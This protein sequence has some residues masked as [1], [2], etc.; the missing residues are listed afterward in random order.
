MPEP[1]MHLVTTSNE[2]FRALMSTRARLLLDAAGYLRA[3]P[4]VR[5]ALTRPLVGRLLSQSTQL[6]ELLDA[7]GA[8]RNGTWCRLRAQM[9]ALKRFAG[10]SYVLLHIRHVLPSY[11]LFEIEHDF[12]QATDDALAFSGSV[13][14]ETSNRLWAHA[15]ELGLELPGQTQD[16]SLYA[17][18]LPAGRLL[19]DREDSL[20]IAQRRSVGEIVTHLATAFLNL[21]VKGEVIHAAA[22]TRPE[23]YRDH[24]P[25]S[26]TETH[27]RHLEISFH[28]LQALYDTYVT[29]TRTERLDT[30][31]PVLRGHI[32]VVYHLL[33]IATQLVHYEERHVSCHG[34]SR[35]PALVDRD[36]LIRV[37]MEYALAFA[38]YYLASAENLCRTMLKRYAEVAEVLVSA[39]RY[40]GFHVRPSTLVAK[41]V[42]HYG[43]EVIMSLDGERYDASTPL[44]I[45]RA[46]EKIN[47]AKRRWLAA[48][49]LRCDCLSG[50]I[51]GNGVNAKEL[52]RRLV[53]ELAEQGKV[54]I[55]EKPLKMP[56][57]QAPTEGVLTDWVI[58]ELARLQ[59]L[60]KID[61][62][63]ELPVTFIGDRRV[64]SDIEILARCGY[65][66]DL[67]GN[68]IP[69]PPEIGYLRR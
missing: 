17:E 47:A 20:A 29:D 66:E 4:A 65:G 61:I 54:V 27:L 48:E 14:Y 50:R 44:E 33:E 12:R 69:L 41:I 3:H 26:I 64:L 34:A 67:M 15:A 59:A 7:Y 10:V 63:T 31:L 43:S 23:D 1:A 25:E 53:S 39:P 68:N 6:E 5:T 60:G 55:Y 57:S 38:S 46:N 42:N 21:A 40:R 56:D 13:L 22:R 62:Q 32:S 18:P 16:E 36:G 37:L 30:D 45:F 28:N 51:N 24:L 35:G 11:R 19:A 58:D 49:V 2:A 52:A 9:A 8:S